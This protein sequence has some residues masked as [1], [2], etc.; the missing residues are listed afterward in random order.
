[1]RL[2]AAAIVARRAPRAA[3]IA[4]VW[5]GVR[6]PLARGDAVARRQ[7]RRGIAHARHCRPAARGGPTSTSTWSTRRSR[8]RTAVTPFLLPFRRR[9]RRHTTSFRP[10][11]TPPPQNAAQKGGSPPGG[12]PQPAQRAASPLSSPKG[13][14]FISLTATSASQPFACGHSVTV[15]FTTS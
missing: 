5:V 13:N 15:R 14:G 2:R 3:V 6:S 7:P 11:C 1:M 8:T 12:R 4:L 10:P 9:L